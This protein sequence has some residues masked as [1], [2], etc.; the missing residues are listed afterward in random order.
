MLPST[1]NHDWLGKGFYAYRSLNIFAEQNDRQLPINKPGSK[2]NDLL[3]RNLDCAVIEYLHAT[4]E[5]NSL[6]LMIQ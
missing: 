5:S 3:I 1:N 6:R 4:R 2:G